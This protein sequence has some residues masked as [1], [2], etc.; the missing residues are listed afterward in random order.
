MEF[1][2]FSTATAVDG[3]AN[4]I[5]TAANRSYRGCTTN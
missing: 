2:I 5:I 4:C 3:S 1:V